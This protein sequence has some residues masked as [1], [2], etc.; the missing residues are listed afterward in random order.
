[1]DET[2][3]YYT[4][5]VITLISQPTFQQPAHLAVEFFGEAS[6][7]ERLMEYAGRVCYMSQHNPA[8]K[9][10]QKY[11]EHILEV[12]H[13]SV[14]EHGSF[15]FLVEGVSRSLT[16]ELIRHRVGTTISQLSQRYV[17]AKDTAFVYPPL[18]L[19][20]PELMHAFRISCEHALRSYVQFCD[21]LAEKHKELS[22]TMLKKRV[23]EASR[24]ILPNATETKLV[25]GVNGRA[26]RHILALR[27]DEAADLEIRRF[28]RALYRVAYEHIPHVLQDITLDNEVLAVSFPKV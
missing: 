16:H 17:D 13:G 9:T 18:L 2:P 25:W 11:I 6:D 23:R 20:H 3:V 24:S 26:I 8:K 1:M 15:V 12:G 21:A 22:G 10:T 27:G 4:E 7:A 14:L 28:A 19:G 5:P